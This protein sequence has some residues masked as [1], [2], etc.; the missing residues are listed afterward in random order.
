MN[1]CSIVVSV[2]TFAASGS[3]GANL[4]AMQVSSTELTANQPAQAVKT[5]PTPEK[6]SGIAKGTTLVAEFS[7]GLNAKKLKAGDKVKAVRLRI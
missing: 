7:H 6:I 2:M 3:V 5:N 1:R 4:S